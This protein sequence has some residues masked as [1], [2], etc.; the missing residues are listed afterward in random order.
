MDASTNTLLASNQSA[1]K[2]GLFSNDAN[3]SKNNE[4]GGGGSF[5]SMLSANNGVKGIATMSN[6]TGKGLPVLGD[7][8]PLS[9]SIL[10]GTPSG[11]FNRPGLVLN[12]LPGQT[13]L[14]D[15]ASVI[16]NA[17][18]LDDGAMAGIVQADYDMLKLRTVLLNSASSASQGLGQAG[19][20][21]GV[22]PAVSS[23]PSLG[24]EDTDGEM[25]VE[26]LFLNE[27]L[28]AQRVND[29]LTTLTSIL[30]KDEVFQKERLLLKNNS[31]GKA[32]DGLPGINSDT[33]SDNAIGS[34]VEATQSISDKLGATGKPQ[35]SL[36]SP[37]GK[38]DWSANIATQVKWMLSNN[39]QSAQMRVDPQHLGPMDIKLSM[40]DGQINVSIATSHNI[41][42]EA[43]ES[44]AI[45][46]RELLEEEGEVAVNIDLNKG[47]KEDQPSSDHD[48]SFTSRLFTP[49][50]DEMGD[51]NSILLSSLDSPSIID[52]YA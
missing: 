37:A 30:V 40:S 42:K 27:E 39:L 23:L 38:A 35:L 34:F 31:A 29:K 12:T 8:L 22:Q 6:Q 16:E 26:D 21:T 9:G 7:S 52:F 41:V 36:Y 15:E 46:L 45:Q 50:A 4:L 20:T 3:S 32:V 33:K 2:S 11:F 25:S 44:S 14:L 28:D 43:L 18:L 47:S 48:K 51:K 49:L 19:T 13:S 5:F 10:D 1:V 17:T 24:A